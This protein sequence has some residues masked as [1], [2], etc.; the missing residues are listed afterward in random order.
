MGFEARRDERWRTSGKRWEKVG[1][2]GG[3]REK[4]R[5]NEKL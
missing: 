4:M 3:K 5:K 1:K 2:S